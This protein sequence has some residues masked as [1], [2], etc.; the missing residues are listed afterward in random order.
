MVWTIEFTK[1]SDRSLEKLSSQDNKRI[2]KYLNEQVAPLHNP[3]MLGRALKGNKY[4]GCWR[5][6]V[7]DYRVIAEIK[8]L[9]VTIAVIEIGHRREV[10][11]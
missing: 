10:Y 9:I 5:Y 8:D 6:R 4:S 1:A 7:G 11:R 2:L 3:R